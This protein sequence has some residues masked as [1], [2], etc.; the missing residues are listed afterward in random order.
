MKS[1][2]VVKC[3][4]VLAKADQPVMIWGSPGVGKSAVVNQF[5]ASAGKTLCE[6]RATLLDPVDLRGLMR[7]EGGRTV[8]CPPIFLPNDPGCVL[9]IDELPTAPPLVQ[10]ALYQLILDRKLGE[11]ELP[12]DCIII[13]AGNRETDRAAVSK[14][15]TPLANR[16]THIDYE[17]DVKDWIDWAIEADLAIEVI[18]GIRFSAS[19]LNRFN[20]LSAEKAQATPRSW[21]FVSKIVKSNPPQEV[22][23]DLIAG[24]VGTAV[25]QEFYGFLEDWKD[26]PDPMA[27]LH[28]PVNGEVPTKPSVLFA[29]CQTLARIVDGKTANNFF[30]YAAKMVKNG[31]ADFA[32]AMVTDATKRS[33]DLKETAGYVAWA[34][35]MGKLYA[36]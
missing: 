21:E 24:T 10:A 31:L 20:P 4:G 22:L 28:D 6:I 19:W 16:F 34:T 8:W 30:C 36:S 27:I 25:A 35:K 17:V 32:V 18:A 7:I 13:A 15:P 29:L 9:F 11:Y 33:K 26:L 14:M 12:A 1:S 23:L 2:S 3:L 5:V